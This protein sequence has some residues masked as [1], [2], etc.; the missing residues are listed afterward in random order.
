MP[1]LSWESLL[2]LQQRNLVLILM[3]IPNWTSQRTS[4][5]ACSSCLSYCFSSLISNPSW[6]LFWHPSLTPFSFPWSPWVKEQLRW[7]KSIEFS[8]DREST[9]KKTWTSQAFNRRWTSKEVDIQ[10]QCR[11]IQLAMIQNVHIC[12]DSS[13]WHWGYVSNALSMYFH[14]SV[15]M[16]FIAIPEYHRLWDLNYYV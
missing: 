2:A 13:Q 7:K 16:Q 9:P 4:T 12:T 14:L 6:S 1:L 10:V 15:C 3:M 5:Y 11:T 8:K